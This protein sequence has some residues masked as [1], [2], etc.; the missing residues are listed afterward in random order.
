MPV[1]EKLSSPLTTQLTTQQKVLQDKIAAAEKS[2]SRLET[3]ERKIAIAERK[4][5]FQYMLTSEFR[6]GRRI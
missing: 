6:G 5:K 1:L 2:K 4:Q 3:M